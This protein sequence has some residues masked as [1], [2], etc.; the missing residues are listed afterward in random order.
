M[1]CPNV[2]LCPLYA[3]FRLESTK[4]SIINLYCETNFER[5]ERK[6]LKDSRQ[7][8]PEKLMPNGNYLP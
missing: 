4:N 1:K 6:R 8:V 5:C 2:E 3:K 7:N